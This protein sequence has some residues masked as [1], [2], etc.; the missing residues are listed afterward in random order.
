MGIRRAVDIPELRQALERLFSLQT[1]GIKLGLEPVTELLN[2]FGNPQRTFPSIHIAGTN[3]KGSVSSMIASILRAAGLRVGLYTSPHLIDFEERI[4]ING[5]PMEPERLA[6]YAREMMPAIERIGC[7]FF[8]GTTAMGF[9]YF[10]ENGV[11]VA[12]VETGMGGRL[13]ATNILAPL[14]TAVTSISYDHTKHLGDS[15]EQIAFEKAGIFKPET[16]AVVG[17]VAPRLRQVFIDRAAAVG[18]SLR[19]VEDLCRAVYNDMTFDRTEASFMIGGRE[20]SRFAIDLVGR[21]Q[22]ENARVALSVVESLRE[23]FA[24]DDEIVRR[25]MAE[26]R[27]NTGLTG[28]F[29]SIASNPRIVLDVAHNADGA[30]VLVETI[31]SLNGSRK[32]LRIVYGAVKEKD[33]AEIVEILKPLVVKLHAVRAD[34]HRSLPADE[35]AHHATAAGIPT[36]IA[37]SVHQGVERAVSEA[38]EDEVVLICGSFHVVGEALETMER[39]ERGPEPGVVREAIALQDYRAGT[40]RDRPHGRGDRVEPYRAPSSV[41]NGDPPRTVY[42]KDVVERR[43]TVKDWHPNEQPRERMMKLGAGAL[44]DAELLAILLRTGTKDEDVIQV[45]RNLLRRF[46]N[47]FAEMAGRDFKELQKISGVGPT[48][49]VMLAAAFEIGRRVRVEPF[50]SRPQITSPADVANLYIPL[51]RDIRKEQFHVL[52]LNSANQVIRMELIS[53]GNLNS[54]IAHPREVYRTAIVENAAS[55][56]GL[57]N[58]PSGNPTPSREDIAI[59]KQL[60][61]SGRIVGIPFHD[62]IIIAGEEFVSLAELG[63]V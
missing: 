36:E 3:G 22:I 29:D 41:P 11:D 44:S 38:G 53:E 25:G 33:V 59:T 15:L 2:E 37:G 27:A 42:R 58:H 19:F 30:R 23:R 34:N 46:H 10:A 21:H 35:I 31:S 50:G 6:V 49:A 52:V 56:I 43:I 9:R 60:V 20:L 26:I 39:E 45:S 55:I 7:T 12:V 40:E 28:R 48:K 18:A 54:S 47:S 32:N 51:L 62:H 8:E 13:D 63:Y 16:P 24:L 1:F 61:E 57:H 17:P 5:V 14:V 4:R